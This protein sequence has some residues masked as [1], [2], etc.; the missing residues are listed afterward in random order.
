MSGSRRFLA[1]VLALL[2]PLI[3]VVASANGSAADDALTQQVEAFLR[4][5]N[6]DT[7]DQISVTINTPT[8]HMPTCHDPEPFLPGQGRRRTGRITV[9]IHC[10][11]DRPA[12]RY[13]QADVRV[14][15]RYFV[16]SRDIVSGQTLSAADISPREG[17]ITRRIDRLVTDQQTIVGQQ[18]KRRIGESTAIVDNMLAPPDV[19]SRGDA[20]KVVS[21][22]QGFSITTHGEALDDAA[23]GQRVRVRTSNGTVVSGKPGGPGIVR[24][25]P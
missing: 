4:S 20:V 16:A 9:G 7:G 17:D 10:P 14:S 22:G 25:G 8:A 2:I 5:V 18:A 6:S 21:K 13:V 12:T 3:S 11:G 15:G 24:I 23:A 1:G 19:I